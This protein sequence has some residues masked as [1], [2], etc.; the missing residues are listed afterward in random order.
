ME[1]AGVRYLHTSCFCIRNRTSER[2]ERLRWIKA[3]VLVTCGVLWFDL[4][5]SSISLHFNLRPLCL[6]PEPLWTLNTTFFQIT[7]PT[8]PIIMQNLD[9]AD[10]TSLL[11]V[12]T[13][14]FPSLI[15]HLQ[16]N[17]LNKSG[18]CEMIHSFAI[19]RNFSLVPVSLLTRNVIVYKT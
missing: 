6:R 10:Y 14:V 16:S 8:T 13:I 12:T 9:F 5:F 7:W 11:N 19:I 2:S 1:S 17:K 3:W 15:F 4:V 18:I